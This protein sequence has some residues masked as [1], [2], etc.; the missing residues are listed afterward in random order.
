MKNMHKILLIKAK[1]FYLSFIIK[2]VSLLMI[3]ECA[4]ALKLNCLP[5]CRIYA[6]LIQKITPGC[7]ESLSN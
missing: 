7:L 2:P 4:G 6:L 1:K 5:F 3:N